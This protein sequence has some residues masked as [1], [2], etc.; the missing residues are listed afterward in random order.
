VEKVL[1]FNRLK[2]TTL[3]EEAT[4]QIKKA[5][6]GGDYQPG[7]Y[8]PPERDLAEALDV[9]R[10]TI[11]EALKI[12]RERGLLELD[13]ATRRYMTRMPDLENCVQPIQEQ[14]SWL[15]QVSE[16]NI[17]DFWAVIPHVLGLTAQAA[18]NVA[19]EKDM[20]Q[21]AYRLD[22][23]EQ[24]G[25]NFFTCCNASYKF[26]LCMAEMTGNRLILLL[27]K[28]FENVIQEEFPPILSAMEQEGP[29][30]LIT[31]HRRILEGVKMKSRDFIH[32]AV[33]DRV[34]NAER[35]LLN[36]P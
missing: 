10:P 24:S 26:G 35:A 15:I 28:I 3:Y 12:L 25:R 19:T 6:L 36:F 31:F 20:Q 8:L 22:E 1:P 23:M 18:I 21:L 29:R 14:I 11:R 32:Q 34:E 30:N 33:A 9:G 5:I 13:R 16:K 17:G 27:W 4:R 7:D 2:K